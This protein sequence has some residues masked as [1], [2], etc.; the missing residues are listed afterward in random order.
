VEGKEL[1]DVVTA[2]GCGP[3]PE[4]TSQSLMHKTV[5]SMAA[6]HAV[7]VAHRDLKLDNIMVSVEDCDVRIIDFGMAADVDATGGIRTTVSLLTV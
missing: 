5:E 6:C 1:F 7:G 4:R 3:I 2:T